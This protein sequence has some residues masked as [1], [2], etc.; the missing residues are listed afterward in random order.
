[1]NVHCQHWWF[2][3]CFSPCSCPRTPS[4]WQQHRLKI[5]V[6]CTKILRL[7]QDRLEIFWKLSLRLTSV[8]GELTW[9]AMR[10]S[11]SPTAGKINDFNFALRWSRSI[12]VNVIKA[13]S[14]NNFNMV[15]I[16]VKCSSVLWT[17]QYY[18]FQHLLKWSIFQISGVSV[19]SSHVNCFHRSPGKHSFS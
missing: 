19:F 8:G 12:S 1:M 15:H 7:S 18:Y 14:A 11:I 4:P 10:C 17:H 13:Y 3:R 9:L 5:S 2:F 16:T 6:Y